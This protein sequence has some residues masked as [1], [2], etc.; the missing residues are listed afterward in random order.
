MERRP[1][2]TWEEQLWIHPSLLMD[3][4]TSPSVD[5]GSLSWLVPSLLGM[6]S[7]SVLKGTSSS[8]A[9]QLLWVFIGCG[10]WGRLQELDAAW[11]HS[12][13]LVYIQA[14]EGEEQEVGRAKEEQWG[15]WGCSTDREALCSRTLKDSFFTALQ[16]RLCWRHRCSGGE[17]CCWLAPLGKQPFSSC[18][19]HLLAPDTVFFNQYTNRSPWLLLL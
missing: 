16:W 8:G 19:V 4:F 6:I 18:F 10:S 3:P 2:W 5:R 1:F 11:R 15:V 13:A 12:R 17:T 14:T 7:S 9:V